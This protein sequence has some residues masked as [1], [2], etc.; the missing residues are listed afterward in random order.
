MRQ[1]KESGK[2]DAAADQIPVRLGP[3]GGRIVAET[4]IGLLWGDPH[5]FLRQDP[6]WT[7]V[8]PA[9]GPSLTM[10]DLIKFALRL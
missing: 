6:G 8:V 2:K 10:G 9:R 7:P 3:V 5:S 1:V 4:L